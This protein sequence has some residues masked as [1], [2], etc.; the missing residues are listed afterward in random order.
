MA[1]LHDSD[2]NNI[3]KIAGYLISGLVSAM[4]LFSGT[5]KLIGNDFLVEAMTAINLV[6]AMRT[7]GLIEITA[8][9]LYWIPK[10]MNFGFFLLCSYM[11][12]VI[13]AELIA[14][15]GVGI[16]MPG[17]PLAILLYVGTFLRKKEMSGFGI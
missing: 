1:T 3:R 5:M 17:V 2:I 4:L 13:A 16:P 12:G 9:I 14:M 8:V 11:G 10:T 15:Q 6:P 7:I